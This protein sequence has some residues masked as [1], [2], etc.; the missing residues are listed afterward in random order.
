MYRPSMFIL[1]QSVS[2]EEVK[3]RFLLAYAL[4]WDLNIRVTCYEKLKQPLQ[5]RAQC[6]VFGFDFTDKVLLELNQFGGQV[7]VR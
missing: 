4:G 2:E 5:R 6:G 1:T 7:G 3:I